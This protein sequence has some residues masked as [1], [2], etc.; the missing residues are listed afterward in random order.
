MLYYLFLAFIEIGLFLSDNWKELTFTAIASGIG[1]I[2][3]RRV[4]TRLAFN[5]ALRL[6]GIN[7]KS[8]LEKK[9]DWLMEQERKRG[10]EWIVSTS[11]PYKVSF[12]M[13][14][15]KRFTLL[16]M[17]QSIA[18][19]TKLHMRWRKKNMQKWKSRKFILAVGTGLLV[20]LNEGLDLGWSNESVMYFVGIIATWILGESAID[21]KRV[22]NTIADD[23]DT[24]SKYN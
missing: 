9:V 21:M 20:V 18:R 17:A 12:R 5:Y 13:N 10:G 23:P 14:L 16:L 24:E 7:H 19:F 22:G 3:G 1:V 15:F 8:T 6:M 2:L 4:G 11:K